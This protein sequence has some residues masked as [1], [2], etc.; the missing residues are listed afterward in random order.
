M[1]RLASIDMAPPDGHMTLYS[2]FTGR[3]ALVTGGS[4]RIGA[5]IAKTLARGATVAITYASRPQPRVRSTRSSSSDE[6][7][8]WSTMRA[9]RPW[10]DC[11]DSRRGFR[12]HH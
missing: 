9:L 2:D 3:T 7:T 8:F 12:A 11:V 1:Q 4:R 6:W 5:G 10:H